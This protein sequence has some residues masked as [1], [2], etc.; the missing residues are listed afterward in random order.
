MTIS[1]DVPACLAFNEP[2]LP[3]RSLRAH[4]T[5]SMANR[6]VNRQSLNTKLPLDDWLQKQA[7]MDTEV[8]SNFQDTL[9]CFQKLSF[10][11]LCLGILETVASAV[12]H[13]LLHVLAEFKRAF[14]TIL[15]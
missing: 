12:S 4:T 6:F 2:F 11:L 14:L 10:W 9:G 5:C 1:F 7:G 3:D 8:H 13:G 15:Y